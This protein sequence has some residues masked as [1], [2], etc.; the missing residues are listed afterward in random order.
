MT[1]TLQLERELEASLTA[2]AQSMGVS[3]ETYIRTV[4]EQLALQRQPGPGSAAEFKA[5]LDALAEGSV[6][7]P[8]L[9]SDAFTRARIY[10]D[11]D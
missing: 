11:H 7:L 9:P 8:L 5:T 10:H 6:D 1:I 3:L 2:R 4:I